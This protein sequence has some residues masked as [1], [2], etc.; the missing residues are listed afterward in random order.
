MTTAL[1]E[2]T[3]IRPNPGSQEEFLA[4]DADVACGGGAAGGGKGQPLNSIV[5]T[6]LGTSPIGKLQV[7][8]VVSHPSGR[9]SRIVGIYPQGKKQL[10]RL[11]LENGAT[12]EADGEHLWLYSENG[13]EWKHT[14]T[15]TLLAM[16]T[17]GKP[18]VIPTSHYGGDL[19][20]QRI[21]SIEESRIDDA[22][23][24]RVDA[25]DGLYLTEDFIVTHNTWGLLAEVIRGIDDPDYEAVIF[26]RNYP[27]IKNAGG[28]W[29]K[30]RAIFPKFGGKPRE[31]DLEWRFPSGAKCKFGHMQLEDDRYNWDGSEI[32]YIGFDQVE[33]FTAKMVFYM[34]SRNRS[35]SSV[36]PYVRMTANP[37]PDSWLR[38]FLRWWIDDDT[39]LAIPEKSGKIRWFVLHEGE[40]VDW[41]DDPIDLLER[42]EPGFEKKRDEFI[43]LRRRLSVSEACVALK[44]ETMPKSFTFIPSSVY[45]NP[46]LLSR[47]PE[48]LG[49]LKALQYI[50]RQR[51]LYGNWNIRAKAGLIFQRGWFEIVDAIPELVEE[52]RYWDRAGV[53]VKDDEESRESQRASWTAGCR[54]GRTE[55]NVFYIRDVTRFQGSPLT[56]KQTIQN[57]AT[58]DGRNVRIGIEQ[59]PGQAGKAESLDHVRDLAGYNVA[60]NLVR[61]S[62]GMR[63]MPLSAQVEAQNVKLLRGPWNE[64]FL[65][66]AENFD[67]T[68]KG[69]CDQVDAAS[70]AFH[71]LTNRKRAGTWGTPRGER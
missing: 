58:I 46:T 21:V 7:G 41:A 17:S 33:S 30:S 3:V 19:Q 37:D 47:N 50:D 13:I 6:P 40:E 52:I 38:E 12:C 63:A 43:R 48:Y 25:P 27:Q 20:R 57:F 18:I 4:T 51:L 32:T 69:V 35:I 64:P 23:C 39:G 62:K 26:R 59:D 55:K 22:V 14:S 56:V 10:Y 15:A 24:I 16:T 60:L 67:G 42:Y 44:I 36:R 66:E 29:D 28:L 5:R 49:N 1:L 53:E 2:P 65:R 70:G 61:E 31:T 9:P 11:T 45:D 8:D 71:L 34:F 68:G 54:M